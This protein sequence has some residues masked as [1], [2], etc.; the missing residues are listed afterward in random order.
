MNEEYE[1]EMVFEGKVKRGGEGIGERIG[2][3]ETEV[4]R[5]EGVGD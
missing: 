5:N 3:R 2:E 1:K 4:I